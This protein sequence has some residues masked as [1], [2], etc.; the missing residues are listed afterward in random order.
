MTFAPAGGGDDS[1]DRLETTRTRH[2]QIEEDD[3]DTDLVERLDGVLGRSGDGANLERGI[4]F[5]H[6]RQDRP[7]DRRIVDDHQADAS[8]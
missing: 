8:A 4:A 7:G 2:F 5:D 6:A 1:R 3:I